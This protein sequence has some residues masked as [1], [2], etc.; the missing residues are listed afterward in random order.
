MSHVAAYFKSYQRAVNDVIALIESSGEEPIIHDDITRHI[1]SALCS[2]VSGCIVVLFGM[3]L[4]THRNTTTSSKN[5]AGNA[6]LDDLSLLEILLFAYILCYTLL[7]SALE[8]LRAA[9]KAVYACF[10]EHP[11][12]YW[13]QVVVS[14][15]RMCHQLGIGGNPS[16]SVFAYF[17]EVYT[18][19]SSSPQ[20]LP[21]PTQLQ[22][23]S[24]TPSQPCR[25]LP[26]PSPATMTPMRENGNHP[27]HSTLSKP[28]KW[29]GSVSINQEW[30]LT[31]AD[32]D[33][34]ETTATATFA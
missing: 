21:A 31:G 26:P 28:S 23:P 14:K 15:R 17:I 1:C 19:A 22:L 13:M 24:Y 33:C 4:T 3:H 9:I 5:A 29:P 7:F 27:D 18:V 12:R 11:L 32:S 8:P 10:A 6:P 34:C 2:V 25:R 16:S 30:S 20:Q